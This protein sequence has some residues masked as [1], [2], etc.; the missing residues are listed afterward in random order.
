MHII[1]NTLLANRIFDAYFGVQLPATCAQRPAQI[2]YEN[3][4]WNWFLWHWQLFCAFK[5]FARKKRARSCW[6]NWQLGSISSTYARGI[7]AG[8]LFTKNSLPFVEN[9]IWQTA[10]KSGEWRTNL[11]NFST[12]IWCAMHSLSWWNWTANFSLNSE[13]RRLF[14]WRTKFGEIDPRS[15]LNVNSIYSKLTK[16]NQVGSVD[17]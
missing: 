1:C 8:L 7:C 12:Q 17:D 13:R 5:R 6:W 3:V 10:H 9:C 16:R 15:F 11:A 14:A 2:S 4:W